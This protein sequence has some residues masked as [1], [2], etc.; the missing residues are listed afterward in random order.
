MDGEDEEDGKENSILV[1]RRR[2]AVR[3][4]DMHSHGGTRD[5]AGKIF[6]QRGEEGP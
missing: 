3:G 2:G 4:Q 6:S 1:Q 5:E